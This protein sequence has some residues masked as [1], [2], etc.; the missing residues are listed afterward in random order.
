MGI[1]AYRRASAIADPT[2]VPVCPG[3]DYLL[4]PQN[5]VLG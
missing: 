4:L 2:K 1:G 5:M 3:Y